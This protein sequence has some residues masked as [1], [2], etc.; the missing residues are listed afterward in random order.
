MRDEDASG[1]ATSQ[2][3]LKGAAGVPGQNRVAAIGGFTG[4]CAGHNG[5]IGRREADD[6]DTRATVAARLCAGRTPC[7]TTPTACIRGTGRAVS[8][9]ATTCATAARPACATSCRTTTATTC[10]RSG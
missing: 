8:A 4:T 2:R 1:T 3:E 6:N 9:G 5:N 7:A 10:A